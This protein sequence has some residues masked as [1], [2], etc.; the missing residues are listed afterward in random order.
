MQV[1]GDGDSDRDGNRAADR[2]AGVD[3]QL[4]ARYPFGH[5]NHQA[6]GRADQQASGLV[7]KTHQRTAAAVFR[8]AASPD[9]DFTPWDGGARSHLS[10][11]WLAFEKSRLVCSFTPHLALCLN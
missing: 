5:A 11:L 2:R 6:C 10:D 3:R 7:A 8:K 9:A 4:T 1:F